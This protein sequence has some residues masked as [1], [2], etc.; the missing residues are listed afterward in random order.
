MKSSP[1]YVS[2]QVGGGFS[3]PFPAHPVK[4]IAALNKANI[5]NPVAVIFLLSLLKV[6]DQ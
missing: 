1:C 5:A 3:C 4:V 6:N 2:S